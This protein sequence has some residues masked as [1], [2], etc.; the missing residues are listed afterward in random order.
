MT[1]L[2]LSVG[3]N[4]NATQNIRV[5]LAEL[6]LEFGKTVCSTVFESEAIGFKGDNFLNLVLLVETDKELSGIAS[7]LKQLEDNL[8]RDRSQEKFSGRPI[9]VDIL[10]Y[11]NDNGLSCSIDLPRPEITKNAF[12]LQPLAELL[13]NQVHSPTGKTFAQLWNEYDKSSQKLW[14]I[15]FDWKDVCVVS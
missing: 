15:D 3:S 13:P 10:L 1:V 14:P 11:G 5:A 9:D 4:I 12:V 6:N 2:A 7:F 8:G